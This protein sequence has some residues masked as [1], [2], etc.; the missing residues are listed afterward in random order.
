MTAYNHTIQFI[1]ALHHDDKHTV[2]SNLQSITVKENSA[3]CLF[4]NQEYQL[5]FINNQ[6][7]NI[8]LYTDRPFAK[9]TSG[10]RWFFAIEDVLTFFWCSDTMI[11]EYSLGKFF[12]PELLEYWT[13]HILLPIF[14]TI[15]EHY[16]FLHAGAVEIDDVP[17]LFVAES[18]GGKSTMTDFFMK[19]G[20]AMVSDD[21]VAV[22]EEEGKFLAVPSHPHYRPYRKM[23]ELGFFVE[24]MSTSPKPM[25]AIYVLHRVSPDAKIAIEELIGIEKFKFLRFNS[26]I[27]LSFLKSQRLQDLSRLAENVPVYKIMVP[28]NLERLEEVYQYILNHRTVEA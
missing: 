28:W 9:K 5:N 12:T 10:Q 8:T 3:L 7:R 16:Y 27:N 23:E 25:G 11:V 6:G 24:N 20:H 2:G 1:P 22:I 18:F 15:E 14:L 4:E 19:Q 21:K 13:L 17:I 26:E